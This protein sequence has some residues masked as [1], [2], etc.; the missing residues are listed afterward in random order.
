MGIIKT[1]EPRLISQ[2]RGPYW[3]LSN[4]Y[5]LPIVINDITYRTSEHAY[6]AAKFLKDTGERNSVMNIFEP[7]K[8]KREADRIVAKFLRPEAGDE[9][10]EAV[11]TPDWDK[12]KVAIMNTVLR[13]KFA[14]GSDMAELLMKTGTTPLLEGN[15]WH[16]ND[17]GSCEPRF[18]PRERSITC[19]P[20]C[21]EAGKN[22]LGKLLMHIR[23]DLIREEME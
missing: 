7:G 22:H 20:E 17:W 16:D 15:W 23:E 4:F 1:I 12:R 8:A 3:F 6:Q 5:P 14:P 21:A 11:L 13:V 18:R 9:D 10:R 2:F 19:K